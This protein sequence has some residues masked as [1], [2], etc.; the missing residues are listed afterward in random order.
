YAKLKDC[1]LPEKQILEK[2]GLYTHRNKP[3]R[4]FSSGM[5][6]RL[7]A[8]L[9]ILTCSKILI[10]DEPTANLDEQSTNLILD[11]IQEYRKER[12]NIIAS[13]IAV[14]ISLADSKVEIA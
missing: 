4:H 11:L 13:N 7:K 10:L 5:L 9:A 14:E 1:F 2:L 6:A 8:G 12:V 3:I